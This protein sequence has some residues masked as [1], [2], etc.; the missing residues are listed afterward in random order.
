MAALAGND[1]DAYTMR[2]DNVWHIVVS[3]AGDV[4]FGFRV[5][6]FYG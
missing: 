5:D 1:R 2:N 6:I 3:P 4:I